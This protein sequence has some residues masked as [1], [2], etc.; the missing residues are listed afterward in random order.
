[1]GCTEGEF[2]HPTPPP[3]KTTQNTSLDLVLSRRRKVAVLEGGGRNK[4]ERGERGEGREG[5]RGGGRREGGR[6]GRNGGNK[7]E[8]VRENGEGREG[9]V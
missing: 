9:G 2:D 5:G 6:E 3:C 8:I 1:M 4:G 7:R